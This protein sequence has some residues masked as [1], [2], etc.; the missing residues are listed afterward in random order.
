MFSQ[1]KVG[2]VSAQRHSFIVKYKV[3]NWETPSPGTVNDPENEKT[4]LRLFSLCFGVLFFFSDYFLIRYC[5]YY[6]ILE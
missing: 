6:Y 1:A 2:P 3:R 4:V 5:L